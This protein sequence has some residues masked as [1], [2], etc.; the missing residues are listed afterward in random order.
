MSNPHIFSESAIFLARLCL[1]CPLPFL[2]EIERSSRF[3]S[4]A[5]GWR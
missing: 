1:P 2:P 3:T 5:H 4:A